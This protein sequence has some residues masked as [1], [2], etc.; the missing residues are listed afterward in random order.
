MKTK[1]SVCALFTALFVSVCASSAF[2]QFDRGSGITDKLKHVPNV[3]SLIEGKPPITTSLDDA[4]FGVPEKDTFNPSNPQPLESLERTANGGFILKPGFYEMRVQ[5]YCLHA[6][7]YAPSQGDGY[8]YAPLEGPARDAL[9]TILRN[10]VSQPDIQQSDIQMLIWAILARA[11]FGDLSP[12]LKT[13]AARLLS[14]QQLSELNHRALDVLSSKA[15]ETAI[16]KAPAPVQQALRTEARM[17]ELLSNPLS[18]YSE[19]ERVAVLPGEA[20]WGQGSQNVPAGRW[21]KTPDGYYIRYM[22][23]GYSSTTEQVFVPDGSPAAGNK[24]DHASPAAGNEYDPANGVAVPGNTAKQRLAQ[25]ARCKD[26]QLTPQDVQQ[27]FDRAFQSR[28]ITTPPEYMRVTYAG[29][30]F[31]FDMGIGRQNDL[32]PPT[33]W[34]ENEARQG[35]LKPPFHNP[36][37][38]VLL[39][40]IQ[41]VCGQGIRVNMRLVDLATGVILDSG[42]GESSK[43]VNQQALDR[44]VDQALGKMNTKFNSYSGSW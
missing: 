43:D 2:A 32:L 20:G 4:R 29:G 33:N 25:S 31:K 44:D 15:L 12:T 37:I 8:L 11:K 6:G 7:T 18:S 19:V 16:A 41:P 22:P 5:S 38:R 17:R 3:S 39:G 10:S 21:S 9:V 34:L 24:Y 27:A 42:V 1:K 35:R 30:L 23:T 40:S 26:S 13:V 36:P 14:P 28:G